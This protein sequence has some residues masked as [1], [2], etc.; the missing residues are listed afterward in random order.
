MLQALRL[1]FVKFLQ[2][3]MHS[4]LVVV[5]HQIPEGDVAL[6][7]FLMGALEGGTI[8]EVPGSVCLNGGILGPFI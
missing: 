5:A 4:L 7:L 6:Q 8:P 2:I 1:F 3:A